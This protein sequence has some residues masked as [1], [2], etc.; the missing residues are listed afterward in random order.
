MERIKIYFLVFWFPFILSETIVLDGNLDESAWI[1]SFIIEEYY[2]VVPYTLKSAKVKTTAKIFSN[3]D[4]I[5][6]GFINYQENSS[7][8]SNKSLRDQWSANAEQNGVAIDFDND[9]SKAY[10]F[11]ITLANVQR[12]GIRPLGSFPEFAWDGDWEAITKKH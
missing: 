4:G 3:E 5:Y 8:L 2:E 6:V 12:D 1:D 7:M 11:I 10:M 9:G